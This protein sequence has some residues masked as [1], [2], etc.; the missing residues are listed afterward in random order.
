MSRSA[1]ARMRAMA[2]SSSGWST[3]TLERDSSAAFTSNEG[4]SV[5]APMSTMSPDSTRGRKASCCALLKRWISS[6]KTMV[7]RPARRRCSAAA[8]TSLMSLMPASTAL[9]AT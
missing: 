1:R 2:A 9:K 7:R 8:M 5:V 3:N 6:T 4:F